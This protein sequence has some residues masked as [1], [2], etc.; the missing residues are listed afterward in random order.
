MKFLLSSFFIFLLSA[1]VWAGDDINGL[2]RSQLIELLQSRAEH[3]DAE[4]QFQMGECLRDGVGFPQDKVAAVTWFEK[5]AKQG[6]VE[7]Q[8][9]VGINY[10]LGIDV[11]MDEAKGVKWFEKAAERGEPGAFFYLGG[12]Y[13]HGKGVKQDFVQSFKWSTLFME[14]D[15][16]VITN[17]DVLEN[18]RET[19]ADL[20]TKLTAKQLKEAKN[21]VREANQRL[22]L[23]SPIGY[24]FIVNSGDSLAD[25]A[26][27][28]R[29]QGVA[30]TEKQIVAA[31]PGLNLTT[32][33][34]VGLKL[35][36]PDFDAKIP[37]NTNAPTR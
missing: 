26:Q 21:L 9:F 19:L 18:T 24:S 5:A 15:H 28:Y 33:L 25:I 6:I 30:V 8:M 20:A 23:V 35:F 36:I 4:A 12:A 22:S 13:F 32:N 11:R 3:G 2:T 31:N 16:S 1:T 27:A 14:S 17:I 34:E 10:W 29:E 37:V 7:A